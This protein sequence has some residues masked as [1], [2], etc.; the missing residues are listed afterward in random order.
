VLGFE[1]SLN[2]I[3]ILSSLRPYRTSTAALGAKSGVDCG[4][5]TTR[6][7]L[8]HFRTFF[9]T[10]P[11][12]L[13]LALLLAA[14]DSG[15]VEEELDCYYNFGVPPGCV[16]VGFYHHWPAWHPD[17]QMIS[18]I[19]P[20]DDGR[21]AEL[22][23]YDL[24]TNTERLVLRGPDNKS[25]QAWS[26]DGEWI[27]FGAGKQIYKVRSD[28]TDLT[29]LTFDRENFDAA[30][31]PDGEWIAYADA[32]PV[33]HYQFGLPDSVLQRGTWLMR[34]D[35]SDKQWLGHIRGGRL[36][37]HPSGEKILAIGGVLPSFEYR[38]FQNYL[39]QI[40]RRD[41]LDPLVGR[42]VLHRASYSETGLHAV[43]DVQHGGRFDIFK[44]NV[45]TN[46][47][48]RLTAST[49]N[50]DG[51]MPAWSPDG[52]TI[53]YVN[54]YWR[55]RVIWLMDADGSNRRPMGPVAPPIDPLERYPGRR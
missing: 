4:G 14:C 11:A 51:A 37:W 36:V 13:I 38:L 47:T 29:Q 34:P 43:Y 31:S 40:F 25:S 53:A 24:A 10:V 50:A 27:V 12:V 33:P 22:Y 44:I 35:G 54:A 2:L 45:E 46:K 7:F 52:Q 9:P 32:T 18:Y 5:L 55:E 30:W 23:I 17:G 21:E 20:D 15:P 6:T 19:R 41:T 8:N 26:P 39:T 42:G 49:A 28:G 1:C 16:S 48:V 3:M